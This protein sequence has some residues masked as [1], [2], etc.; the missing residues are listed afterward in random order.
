MSNRQRIIDEINMLLGT[1]YEH[2]DDNQTPGDLYA[3]SLDQVEFVMCL[4][5][6]FGICIEDTD[7]SQWKCF[8]DVV[9]Y[10]DTHTA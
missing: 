3:D 2:I 1:S 8:G 6:A 7:A 5:E 10:I 4:E 9:K